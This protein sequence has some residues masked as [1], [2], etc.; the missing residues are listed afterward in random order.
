MG[1]VSSSN[2]HRSS[3]HACRS[4]A[5]LPLDLVKEFLYHLQP[6]DV[7]QRGWP[8]TLPTK[9]DLAACT[10][11]SRTWRALAQPILFR[12]VFYSFME[13]T[14]DAAHRQPGRT[15]GRWVGSASYSQWLPQK[16]FGMFL[17]FLRAAPD[18]AG[19]IRRLVLA[20]AMRGIVPTAEAIEAGAV[21]FA[22]FVELVQLLPSLRDLG[23]RELKLK[24]PAQLRLSAPP[25]SALGELD[26]DN[27][28]TRL[29]AATAA[30]I[31][32]CFRTVDT[33]RMMCRLSLMDSPLNPYGSAPEPEDVDLVPASRTN[34]NYVLF[35]VANS[36]TYMDALQRSV[37]LE[38][39][40]SLDIMPTPRLWTHQGLI[41]ACSP[42]LQ[43]LSVF[44]SMD[45]NPFE[46]TRTFVWFAAN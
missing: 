4:F 32:A 40:R 41:D 37:H 44:V 31:L 8:D 7:L 28:T 17:E 38:G 39:V 13:D 15:D 29:S 34:V 19:C 30:A 33:L 11:V 36:Q 42:S 20:S 3:S 26:I 24:I 46:Q 2:E 27:N 1:V 9:R 12:D 10:L 43:E 6:A 23:V 5:G 14:S 16:T 45:D 22:Y 21:P 18:L 25:L 35:G